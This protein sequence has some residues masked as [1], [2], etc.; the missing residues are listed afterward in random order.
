MISWTGQTVIF[1]PDGHWST[2]LSVLESGAVW[3]NA[4]TRLIC[5]GKHR[6]GKCFGES[7]KLLE[8]MLSL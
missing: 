1:R 2:L 3:V 8:E 7:S 5:E 6:K 4:T